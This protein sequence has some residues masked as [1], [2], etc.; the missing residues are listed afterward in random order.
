[1][2]TKTNFKLGDTLE[3]NYYGRSSSATILSYIQNTSQ[4]KSV[5]NLESGY[6]IKLSKDN[7][8]FLKDSSDTLEF[9][10]Q[11]SRVWLI[12]DTIED[13]YYM[14]PSCFKLTKVKQK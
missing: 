12:G 9:Y 13:L 7:E 14:A 1:M 3:I 2:K 4:P 6:R 10:P 5:Y 8:V 11:K